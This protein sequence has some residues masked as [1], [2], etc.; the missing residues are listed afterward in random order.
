MA[1]GEF[2]TRGPCTAIWPFSNTYAWQIDSELP[3]GFLGL[4]QKALQ[5]KPVTRSAGHADICAAA[6]NVRPS[7]SKQLSRVASHL[8]DDRETG[9]MWLSVTFTKFR[10]CGTLRP[11][12]PVIRSRHVKGGWK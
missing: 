5:R 6:L 3:S 10:F 7:A 9:Q 1:S 11:W 2:S 4:P 12:Q 8:R